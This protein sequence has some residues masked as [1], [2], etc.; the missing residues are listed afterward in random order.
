MLR[1][2]NAHGSRGAVA[3]LKRIVR[4][5]RARWPGVRIEVRADS[6]FA[7]PAF[8]DYCAA[9]RIAYTVGLIPNPRL[10]QVAAPLLAAAQRQQVETGAEKVRLAGATSYQAGSWSRARRVVSKAE[11]LAE[12]PNT[13]FVVTTRKGPPLA[14]TRGL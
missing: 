2:G 10:E 7:V 14:V 9:E 8:Y 13:R 3:V 11:A 4:G 6:G 1:P 5:L 12:G